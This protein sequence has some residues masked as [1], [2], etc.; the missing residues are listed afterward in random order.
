VLLGWYKM[1]GRTVGAARPQHGPCTMI[2]ISEVMCTVARERENPSHA[3]LQ[4]VGAPPVADAEG[5]LWGSDEPP[6]PTHPQ[7]HIIQVLN[8]S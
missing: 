1:W 7:N 3:V 8:S 2:L 6:N 5:G 4:S